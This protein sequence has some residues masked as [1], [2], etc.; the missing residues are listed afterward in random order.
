MYGWKKNELGKRAILTDLDYTDEVGA[1]R[2]L[3]TLYCIK[4]QAA[5]DVH[6]ASKNGNIAQ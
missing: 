4:Y 5:P 3:L 2:L 1:T 6:S